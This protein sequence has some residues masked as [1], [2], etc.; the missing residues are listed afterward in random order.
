MRLPVKPKN[1]KGGISYGRNGGQGNLCFYVISNKLRCTTLRQ[2]D[3]MGR[4]AL[5]KEPM[6]F[7]RIAL[8]TVLLLPYPSHQH[9]EVLFDGVH[10]FKAEN[11]TWQHA[12]PLFMEPSAPYV[13]ATIVIRRCPC[14]KRLRLLV[15]VPT[16][17]DAFP[18]SCVFSLT[19][20]C[21][22]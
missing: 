6:P 13:Q 1:F 10:P 9:S 20:T 16:R 3:G 7:I 11:G 18:K 2:G 22:P 17:E 5:G 8:K 14:E 12:K 15:H 4:K 19:K 21:H